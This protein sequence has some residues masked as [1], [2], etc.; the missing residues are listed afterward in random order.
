[1]E[2]TNTTPCLFSKI[3]VEILT[4]IFRIATG[5]S[6]TPNSTLPSF[7]LD[8][9]GVTIRAP[10]NFTAVSH[11][12]R[13]AALS[14]RHLWSSLTFLTLKRVGRRRSK[15]FLA[16]VDMILNRAEG[17]TLSFFLRP[18]D[19]EPK[20]MDL[21][22]QILDLVIQRSMDWRKIHFLATRKSM[23]ALATVQGR[24][25][26]LQYLNIDGSFLTQADDAPFT[27]FS[28]APKLIYFSAVQCNLDEFDIPWNQIRKGYFE[29]S[30]PH[31]LDILERMPH[32]EKMEI[33]DMNDFAVEY[34]SSR[35]LVLPWLVSLHVK[36]KGGSEDFPIE[37]LTLPALHHLD[38]CDIDISRLIHHLP[39][40]LSRSACSIRELVIG[41][42]TE[43]V[44]TTQWI[45][46]LKL[47][48][49]LE[50]L[51]IA[52][53]NIDDAFFHS[54][55]KSG[56]DAEPSILPRLQTL[57]V[58]ARAIGAGLVDFLESRAQ[59]LKNV[60]LGGFGNVDVDDAVLDRLLTVVNTHQEGL[61]FAVPKSMKQRWEDRRRDLGLC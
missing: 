34:A 58:D 40:F 2:V 57:E 10:F 28:D 30:R 35:N 45:V 47:V 25:P 50:S 38:I 20:Q 13:D 46:L 7:L 48:P 54:L 61:L 12:W 29:D 56:T 59:V 41:N 1:M 53:E 18:I 55:A 52:G 33:L 24:V 27:M 4:E 16:F 36:N 26:N 43:H 60:K 32:A 11:Y 19:L 17:T 8:F 37:H 6:I 51:L 23:Q 21:Y 9:A 42:W 31:A 39:P 5:R 49:S 22:H 15:S 3:P 14:S 44:G